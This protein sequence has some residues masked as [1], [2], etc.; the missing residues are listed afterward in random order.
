VVTVL[1]RSCMFCLFSVA[2][3]VLILRMMKFLALDQAEPFLLGSW[4]QGPT[5]LLEVLNL[6]LDVHLMS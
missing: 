6:P 3:V 2:A 5:S 1:D 4:C